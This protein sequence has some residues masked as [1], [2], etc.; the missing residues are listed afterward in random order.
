MTRN[1]PSHDVPRPQDG[2]AACVRRIKLGHNHA[3]VDLLYA[4]EREQDPRFHI[5]HP[6]MEEAMRLLRDWSDKDTVASATVTV[7]HNLSVWCVRVM[8][9]EELAGVAERAKAALDKRDN[10]HS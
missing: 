4:L 2:S 8:A 5:L 7:W 3:V 6:M 9:D 10:L 1:L